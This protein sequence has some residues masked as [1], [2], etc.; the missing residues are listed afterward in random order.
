MRT[1]LTVIL[2]ATFLAAC[3][4]SSTTTDVGTDPGTLDVTPDVPALDVPTTDVIE[5]A[6]AV[7]VAPDVA[8][9]VA[10]D[11]GWETVN[12]PLPFGGENR[13]FKELRGIVHLH[14]NLSH[15]G[16]FPQHEDID[17][18]LLTACETEH[19]NAPCVAG[20][21]FVM[22]TDHPG[23]LRDATFEQ[24]LHFRADEG[25]VMVNDALGRPT[26]NRVMCPNGS[27]VSSFLYYGGTEG[28][29]NMPVGIS[30]K[31]PEDVLSTSYDDS[32]PL[33]LAQAAISKV[34]EL[35]GY[36][37]VCHPEQDDLSIERIKAAPLDGIEIFNFHPM[38]MDALQLNLE[39]FIRM[40]AFMTPGQVNPVP[41]LAILLLLQ[42]VANDPIK[43]DGAS[44]F[45]R[46]SSFGA[47]DIHRNVE[48]PTLCTDLDSC[49]NYTYDYPNFAQLLVTG[50]PAILADGDRMDSFQR[51]FRWMS[52]HTR[53]PTDKAG[54]VDEVRNA[55]GLGRSFMAFDMM[56][57]PTGFDFFAVADG[58]AVEMGREIAGAT[59]VDLYVRSP[60]L[61]PPL[62]GI[63]F[64]D[65]GAYGN[66]MMRTKV[67]QAT[68][69][70]VDLV[71]DQPGQGREF[72][73]AAATPGAYRVEV[74]ITPKHLAAA[75]SGVEQLAD[76]EVPYLYS[77]AVFVRP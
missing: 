24:A 70:G 59:S 43:F 1:N 2:V 56:G 32:V 68:A 23:N 49:G 6:P 64:V 3:S 42:P 45:I 40:D 36:A 18:A 75:L 26:A 55:I 77:N 27:L 7:D 29:K 48:V 53:V 25:D 4:S 38:L 5:D 73:L 8:P 17:P 52:N 15:D 10:A 74:W 41:D 72:K 13:G 19:R 20:M 50:G 9:D 28:S 39:Q 69:E 16:C 71:L 57:L 67:Y 62:W 54:D 37:F 12:P 11:P 76:N 58:N 35:G 51:S 14:S 31:I 33:D 63:P 46:L 21:D 47:T 66:A 22:Q 34:H 65:A 44:P 30:G 61:A 60:V